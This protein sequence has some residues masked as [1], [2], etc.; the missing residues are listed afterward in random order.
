[1]MLKLL[2]AILLICVM[3][4]VIIEAVS[5]KNKLVIDR[6][7][8]DSLHQTVTDVYLV[9][10]NLLDGNFPCATSHF[11]HWGLALLTNEKNC[12][13]I[14]TQFRHIT[15]LKLATIKDKYVFPIGERNPYKIVA[16]FKT[17]N[18]KTT[19]KDY[20]EY[21]TV[22]YWNKE[23]NFFGYN[24]QCAAIDI[25][26]HFTTGDIPDPIHGTKLAETA[27]NEL[28]NYEKYKL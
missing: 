13:V 9:K 22:T 1:M 3:I 26:K 21:I 17:K 4:V 25:L 5:F 12:F 19:V 8:M 24:C 28:W 20:L 23:Y 14:G 27:V 2:C 18:S 6:I 7:D 10:R 11:S 16:E 15:E